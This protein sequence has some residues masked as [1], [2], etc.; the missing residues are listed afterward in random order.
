[1]ATGMEDSQITLHAGRCAEP[2][3]RRVAWLGRL[4]EA[5]HRPSPRRAR[6]VLLLLGFIWIVAVCD[7]VLT[8][9]AHEIGGFIELNPFA[10][11]AVGHAPSLIAYKLAMAG[12]ATLILFWFRRRLASE[13]ACWLLCGIHAAL[14]FTWLAYF[15]PLA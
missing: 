5:W 2:A 7:T 13:I 4:A 8:I 10:R 14:A 6:R 15:Q 3:A 9:R 1:M 11:A 12:P